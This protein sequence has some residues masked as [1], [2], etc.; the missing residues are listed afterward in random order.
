MN[1]NR[2]GLPAV[3]LGLLLTAC[4]NIEPWVK[5][6]E[7][8]HLADPIMSFS[9]DPVSDAYIGHLYEVREGARGAEGAH[10]GGCGCN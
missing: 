9:R 1:V 8:A 2:K 6:Y 5:P 7:R 4:S 10:G 3:A